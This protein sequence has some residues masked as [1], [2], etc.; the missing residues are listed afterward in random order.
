M[1]KSHVRREVRDA[2]AAQVPPSTPTRG[3]RRRTERKERE[4]VVK[5]AVALYR[6]TRLAE[7]RERRGAVSINQMG[8]PAVRNFTGAC[9][10][11]PRRVIEKRGYMGRTET[12][13]TTP[14]K[15]FAYRVTYKHYTRGIKSRVFTGRNAA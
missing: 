5:E 2:W 15:G 6:R 9:V 4:A 13:T 3:Q 8:A 12:L 11:V 10:R 14:L 1:N 7:M